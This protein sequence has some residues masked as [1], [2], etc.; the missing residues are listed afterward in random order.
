M[1]MILPFLVQGQLLIDFGTSQKHEETD[2]FIGWSSSL[3]K[4]QVSVKNLMVVIHVLVVLIK[5]SNHHHFF[6]VTM[7]LTQCMESSIFDVFDVCGL[8]FITN[9]QKQANAA[10][11]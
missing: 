9:I 8:L 7:K 5:E 11:P 3:D 2:G 1:I 6:F 4:T 10:P